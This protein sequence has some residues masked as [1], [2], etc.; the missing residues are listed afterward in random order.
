MNPVTGLALGRITIGV[1]TFLA[2]RLSARIFQLD[3]DAMSPY[4]GRLFA[5]REIAIG[6]ATLVSTG[7]VRTRVVAAGAAIDAADGIAGALAARNGEVS[8]VAGGM[9]IAPAVGAVVV[10]LAEIV[11]S[12]SAA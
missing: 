1:L 11:R 4:I 2:P 6:A 5:S 3:A 12:R 9:L 8:R 10:G 7:P